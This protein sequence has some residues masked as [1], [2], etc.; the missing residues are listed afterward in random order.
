ML[1]RIGSCLAANLSYIW[2][3]RVKQDITFC[4]PDNDIKMILLNIIFGEILSN[5]MIYMVFTKV[6]LSE[7]DMMQPLCIK[8]LR[9]V[10][11]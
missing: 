8:F 10:L 5:R 3:A 1:F 4:I 11:A 7:V 9:A 6:Q 2:V